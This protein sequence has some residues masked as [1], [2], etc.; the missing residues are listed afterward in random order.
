[1]K[2]DAM[3]SINEAVKQNQSRIANGGNLVEA[4]TPAPSVPA[5]GASAPPI[6]SPGLPVRGVFTPNQILATDFSEGTQ[7]MRKGAN[8]R[9]AAF[10]PS[11]TPSGVQKV[12]AAVT[13]IQQ[14]AAALLLKT[15]NAKNPDQ[16]VL[17][18]LAGTGMTITVD[19]AGNVVF[20]STAS[21]DGLVH[22]D[23]IW[24]VDSGVAFWRDD[25]YFGNAVAGTG[26]GNTLGE[27]RWDSILASGGGG[28]FMN[29]ITGFS[30]HFGQIRFDS[31]TAAAT[32]SS[33]FAP[34][35][36][37]VDSG[38]TT[39]GVFSSGLPL[40][41]YPGW[42]MNWVFGFA[43][44]R[45]VTV[46]TKFPLVKVQFYCGL[47]CLASVATAA[48][49]QPNNINGR[50]VFFT[51]LR[52][53]SD[54]GAN[55]GAGMSI[56]SVAAGT[57]VYTGTITGGAASAYAG[58][59]VTMTGFGNSANNGVFRVTA[60]SALTLTTVNTSSALD[61][62]G[63]ATIP[64]LGDTT[65]KFE[66]V[67]NQNSSNKRNNAAGTV[68]DTGIVPAENIYYRLELSS[69]AAGTITMSLFGDDGSTATNTFSNVPTTSVVGNI[70]GGA[71]ELRVKNGIFQLSQNTNAT[72]GTSNIAWGPGSKYTVTGA[73]N[74]YFNKTW[75]VGGDLVASH[76]LSFTGDA[77]DI[78]E[79]NSAATLTGYPGLMP[80][81]AWGN[82]TEATPASR[83]IALDFWALVI[84]PGLAGLV[85]NSTLSRYW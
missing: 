15:N 49:W 16:N 36:S 21:G 48:T 71:F 7:A 67:S 2:K 77:T 12:A 43:P 59:Y 28:A 24:D 52:F 66:V 13:T 84:N 46:T 30:P 1:V 3:P 29:T 44:A 54:P 5:P 76:W 26:G 85:P 62:T 9:S 78:D 82:D 45:A 18:I 32:C 53:D 81:F 34:S 37:L 27:L 69:L 61:T 41:D 33:I 51:G 47:S 38:T 72:F 10:P 57:G 4:V 55:G 40:L 73:A 35:G 8:L 20:T 50:P 75:T 11:A 79:N 60:S 39:G 19:A 80:Y 58:Y 25:F 64:S 31:G 14:V 70:D 17:N 22:G 65:F 83:V 6:V 23:P 63:T 68:F 42:K 56:T 74:S